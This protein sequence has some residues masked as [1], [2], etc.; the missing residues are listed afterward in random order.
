MNRRCTG[1]WKRYFRKGLIGIIDDGRLLVR[2]TVSPILSKDGRV[3]G[4]LSI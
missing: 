2:Y 4:S 3:I 1:L